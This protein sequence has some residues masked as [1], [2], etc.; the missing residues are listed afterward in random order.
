MCSTSHVISGFDLTWKLT[1][2]NENTNWNR[3]LSVVDQHYE[4]RI[5]VTT[6]YLGC[7]YF[8]FV[9]YFLFL[10]SVSLHFKQINK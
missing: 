2:K 4:D 10:I 9:L 5:L 6:I 3:I 7:D 8:F 1:K